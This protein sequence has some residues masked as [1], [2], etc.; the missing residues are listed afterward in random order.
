[1]LFFLKER[2]IRRHC[3]KIKD[4]VSRLYA[5][6][7]PKTPKDERRETIAKP[8]G[9]ASVPNIRYSISEI[10]AEDRS[11]NYDFSAVWAAFRF[12][13]DSDGL[14]CKKTV[15]SEL[16]SN[17]NLSFSEMLVRVIDGKKLKPAAVY[18]AAQ[19][20]RKLYS[21]IV[22]KPRY[23]PSKDTC[24]ALLFA[25]RLELEDANDMLSRAGYVLS[26][27]SKRDIILEYCFR[28]HIYKLNDINEILY[29]LDEKTL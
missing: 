19:V 5:P 12:S 21:K 4:Y 9:S 27:S 22:S 16:E 15:L 3:G 28:A 17:R 10:P 20:D 6:P 13:G 24:I 23:K 29:R 1:M 8:D 25:L 18:N 11:D 14:F 7:V 2:R 26:H